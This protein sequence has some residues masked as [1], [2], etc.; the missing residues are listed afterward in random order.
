M[1]HEHKVALFGKFFLVNSEKFTKIP[2]GV[3]SGNSITYLSTDSEA[4]SPP[5]LPLFMSQSLNEKS[6]KGMTF[7]RF[8]NEREI[9]VRSQPMAGAESH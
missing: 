3:I 9:F 4:Y 1:N 8:S 5:C 2:F 7:A 6:S